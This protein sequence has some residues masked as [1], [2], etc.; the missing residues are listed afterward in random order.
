MD[1][2]IYPPKTPII[3]YILNYPVRYYGLIIS[4]CFF[5]GIFLCYKLFLIKKTK[6]DAEVFF[7]YSPFVILISLLGARL[8]YVIGSFKYYIYNPFEIFM[9]NHGGLSIFGAIIFGIFSIFY[10]SKKNKFNFLLHCDVTAVCLPLCQAIGR[11]GN[12]FNQEAFG[13]PAN[14]F[15]KLYVDEQYRPN[16]YSNFEYFHPTFL[17]ESILDI[18]IFVILLLFFLKNKKVK[19]GSIACLYLIFYSG[20]RFIIESIRI[21]SVLS[22]ANIPI[23]QIIAVLLFTT[24]IVALIFINKKSTE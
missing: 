8:F 11:F 1:F 24:G 22:F 18:L 4:I 20:A 13:S 12:F 15:I 6:T 17:Y 2:I 19:N 9:I 7:D 5:V 23:A 3:G 16:K 10:F 14:N 21:D